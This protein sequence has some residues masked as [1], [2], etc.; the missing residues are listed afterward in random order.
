MS[1]KLDLNHKEICNL[2]KINKLSIAKIAKLMNCSTPT[3][4]QILRKYKIQTRSL[5][6]AAQIYNLDETYFDKIDTEEKAYFLGLLYADGNNFTP[7]HTVS[8]SLQESD[9]EILI[10][11][12]NAIKSTRPIEKIIKKLKNRQTQYRVNITNSNFSKILFNKGLIPN[13]SLILTYPTFLSPSLNTSFIRGYFDGD[14]CIYSNFKNHDYSFSIVGTKKLLTNIQ[15]IMIKDLK[16]NQTKLYN[17]KSQKHNNLY[18]MSYS[19]GKNI[20]LIR[21]WLYKDSTIY[22][23]RKFDKFKTI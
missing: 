13:K 4:H 10:K 2:Y 6:K 12:K 3:I 5:S 1:K 18:I 8:I 17:P 14:G 16:L 21:E 22:L 19:G 9:K 15:N 20:R 23:Q 11:F 7:N